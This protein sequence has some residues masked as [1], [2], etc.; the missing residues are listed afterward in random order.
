[1]L[2]PS[3]SDVSNFAKEATTTASQLSTSAAKASGGFYVVP[4]SGT[5]Y[6]GGAGVTALTGAKI[7]AAGMSFAHAD[8]SR[9]YVITASGTADLRVVLF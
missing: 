6:I 1:M 2:S 8:L 3:Q 5:A 7:P 4:E 9:F